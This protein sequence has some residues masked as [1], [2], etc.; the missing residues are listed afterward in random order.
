MNKHTRRCCVLNCRN[1]NY[2]ILS[3]TKTKL[4]K[5]PRNVNR[6]RD[7]VCAIGFPSVASCTWETLITHGYVCKDH[8]E[9]KYVT[10]IQGIT[11][12]A[13]PTIFPYLRTP[14]S[15][16]QLRLFDES[17]PVQKSALGFEYYERVGSNVKDPTVN[18][19]PIMHNIVV[20]AESII[21][22]EEVNFEL[23]KEAKV[24][25]HVEEPIMIKNP[26]KDDIVVEAE[27]IIKLEEVK[28]E[29]NDYVESS[30]T[31]LS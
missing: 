17:V 10:A 20:E 24:G 4:F 1:S 12:N 30:W 31:F 16:P 9:E 14:L 19:N 11:V 3:K 25:S 21:K 28:E 26:I 5:F 7:W 18:Q 2:K 8:F 23:L 27:S 22:L 13:V 6:C 15:E 29:P